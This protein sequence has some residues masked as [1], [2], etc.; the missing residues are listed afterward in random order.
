MDIDP[1]NRFTNSKVNVAGRQV[2][3]RDFCD[4]CIADHFDAPNSTTT[5][6]KRRLRDSPHFGTIVAAIITAV[7]AITIA[8]MST[9]SGET[10][11]VVELPPSTTGVDALDDPR[12]PPDDG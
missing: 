2:D 8:L 3:R 10:P 1:P 6:N 11:V 9:I 5:V 12:A 7:T 4:D